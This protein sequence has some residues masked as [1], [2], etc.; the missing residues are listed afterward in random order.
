MIGFN[1]LLSWKLNERDFKIIEEV[2]NNSDSEYKKVREYIGGYKIHHEKFSNINYRAEFSIYYDLTKIK[3]W[4]GKNN[5]SYYEKYITNILIIPIMS[6]DGSIFLWDGPSLWS[7]LWQSKTTNKYRDNFIFP[8]GDIDDVSTLSYE[9]LYNQNLE[10]IYNF[11]DRYNLNNAFI[12]F[13]HIKS[14]SIKKFKAEFG[15]LLIIN[16]KVEDLITKQTISSLE[17]EALEDF[18]V[19]CKNIISNKFIYYLENHQIV[20]NITLE[21]NAHYVS[22]EDW[23]NLQKTLKNIKEVIEFN[24]LSLSINKAVVKIKIAINNESDLF[25]IFNNS[26]LGLNKNIYNEYDISIISEDEI[27]NNSLKNNNFDDG[28]TILVIE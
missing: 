4:L 5:I 3:N 22:F 27:Y 25:N 17:D 24:V 11:L 26:R 28:Q 20:N 23:L 8:F 12:P 2:L 13:L 16:R 14:D 19:R 10:K 15:S 6:I 18:I 1:R 7:E 21:F 9:N